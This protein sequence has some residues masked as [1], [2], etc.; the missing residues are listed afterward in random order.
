M[1]ASRMWLLLLLQALG[2]YA[3][4]DVQA[5][6]SEDGD[7]EAVL[8]ASGSVGMKGQRKSSI[9]R[10]HDQENAF[11]ELSG[12]QRLY[13]FADHDSRAKKTAHGLTHKGQNP[14]VQVAYPQ[15]NDAS[16]Q[17][18]DWEP[19]VD[20][21]NMASKSCT[22][23]VTQEMG[24]SD[25]GSTQ[26]SCTACQRTCSEENKQQATN[27]KYLFE[28]ALES[29]NAKD[30]KFYMNF[31]SIDQLGCANCG[32]KGIRHKLEMQFATN[33]GEGITGYQ[34]KVLGFN[35]WMGPEVMGGPRQAGSDFQGLHVFEVEDT[36]EPSHSEDCAALN[37]AGRWLAIPGA[38]KMGETWNCQRICKSTHTCHCGRKTHVRCTASIAM[39]TSQLFVYRVR[40]TSKSAV[41]TFEGSTYTGTEWEVSA[42]DLSHKNL[43]GEGHMTVG[44]VILVG[45]ADVYG[46]KTMSQAHEH[47][48]CVPCDMFYESTV[49]SGPFVQDPVGVHAIRSAEGGAP[50]LTAHS[51]ELFRMS[52]LGG[53][54]VKFE[55]GPGLWPPFEV[56]DTI[57]TCTHAAPNAATCPT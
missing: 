16:H 18:P 39:S 24:L 26:H 37:P 54:A 5:T 7:A 17:A 44:R 56:N 12:N 27:L 14:G 32:A 21:V 49:V 6:L 4:Q 34:D 10:R 13:G 33:A 20:M 42:Q 36:E 48:G 41:T 53:F 9:M 47:I 28:P 29:C 8:S 31:S 51:C 46:I 45:N 3:M 57:F 43:A 1:F 23:D 25:Y 11:T 30:V 50:P 52:S 22:M 35:G 15:N 2:T 55:T 40:M 19:H 38:G